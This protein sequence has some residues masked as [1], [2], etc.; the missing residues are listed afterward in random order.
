MSTST[1]IILATAVAQAGAAV[2]FGSFAHVKDQAGRPL[3]ADATRRI[4]AAAAKA[5]KSLFKD[6]QRRKLMDV[7]AGD[8]AGTYIVNDV[9]VEVSPT[10]DCPADWCAPR[11]GHCPTTCPPRLS[12]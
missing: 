9:K 10:F 2:G 5:R 6:Q 4:S 3:W 11:Y 8:T 12:P 1:L 7:K